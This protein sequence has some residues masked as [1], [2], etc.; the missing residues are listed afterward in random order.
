M[1]TAVKNVDPNAQ[2]LGP[3]SYGFAGYLDFQGA[4]TG[5]SSDRI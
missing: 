2:I 1:S 4:S 5:H 3:V